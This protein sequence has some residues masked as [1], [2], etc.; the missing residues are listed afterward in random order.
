MLVVRRT[1]GRSLIIP[2][3]VNSTPVKAT[4]DTAA[5]ITLVSS[6]LIPVLPYDAESVILKGIG[7]QPITGKLVPNTAITI[8]TAMVR[9]D[10][11]VIDMTDSIILGL[12]FLNSCGAIVDLPNMSVTINGES[13]PATLIKASNQS[14]SDVLLSRTVKVPPNSN[15]LLTVE[16][17]SSPKDDYVIVPVRNKCP[18]LVSNVIG[19]GPHC[20]INILNDTGRHVKLKKGTC[21]GHAEPVDEILDSSST[22][23]TFDIRQVQLPTNNNRKDLNSTVLPNHLQELYERSSTN[24]TNKQQST[25]KSLLIEFED[26]FSKSDLDL[27]CLTAVK[28][29]ID[30]KDAPPVKHRMR[31]TP[32][33]FQD[34]E[35]EYL[36]K[37][38]SAGVIQPSTSEWSSAPVLVRKRDGSVRW[39]VDYRALNDRTVK[40]CFPL[41]IIEDC[42]DSLQGAT[43]FCTLDL[44]SGY[45]QIELEESDRKKTAFITR[46]GL[47]EHTRMGMGLCNAPAT[48][49]RAMQLVLRGLTWNQVLVYLD[50]VVILGKNFDHCIEGLRE[51]LLRFRAHSLKLKPKKCQLFRHEVEFLGKLVSADGIKIAPTKAE[52]VQKWPVPTNKKE[53]MA[54]LG[55]V[56]YHRDHVPDFAGVTACLYELAHQKDQPVWSDQHEM[57]FFSIKDL[58]SNPP[59]LSYPNPHDT[60]I[61]DTDASDIAVGAVLSQL[62]DN[63]EK[64][65][66]YASH[67]LM[68][69]QRKYCTTRKELLAVVKFCRHFRHYLLGRRF[70][71]R[72]DHNS[73][74][75]LM[76]FKHIEGQ[77]ARWL[78]ELAQFDMTIVHRS[79]KKHLN[80][81]GMSRIPDRL[82]GCDC[83]NAGA[84]VESLPCK[85][86]PYCQR[87]HT[88]WDRF[89]NDVDDV[90]PLAQRQVT[91]LEVRTASVDNDAKPDGSTSVSLQ[92]LTASSH[93]ETNSDQLYKTQP[94]IDGDDNQVNWMQSYSNQDLRFLQLQDPDISP[95]IAWIESKYKPED[96]E[97]RLQGPATRA[98][99][100]LESCLSISDGVLYYTWMDRSEQNHC[101]VV[102]NSLKTEVLQHCHDS[103]VA[104][105]LGQQKTVER[106]KQ[107][108]LWYRLHSDCIDYVKSCKVCNQNKKAHINP[109]ASLTKFHAGCPMERVHLDILGPFN[110][111]ESGNR[112][113]LM[114]IDQFSKW[115]EMAALPDQSALLI[116]QKF[117]VHFIVTF[118]CPLE[119][120]T[121]QGRNFDGN[122]FKALCDI[123]EIAKTRTTP[124]HPS[125]N[126]QVERY[127]T[128]VLQMIRCYI[129]KNNKRWDVDLPLLAM[130]LH[131]MVHRQTG[132]T[133]NR[134]MLGRE[135]I[136]PIHLLLGTVP[137]AVKKFDPES[138][139]AHLSRSLNEVH[140]LARE[141][142]RT[143]QH[144]Q[145]RDYDLRLSQHKYHAGDLVYKVDSSSK[146][147][148]SKKLK[149][150]WIGPYLVVSDNFPIY[151]IKDRK[152]ESV[153]HHDRLKRCDDREIPIW[154]RRMR[155]EICKEEGVENTTEN[156]DGFEETLHY[157]GGKPI[158]DLDLAA[159]ASLTDEF[160]Q[161]FHGP[162]DIN[163]YKQTSKKES[164]TNDLSISDS[165][166]PGTPIQ[167]TTS[168]IQSKSISGVS[169]KD[170]ANISPTN[171]EVPTYTRSGRTV[172]P[173]ARYDDQ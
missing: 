46:Y 24:L 99:W 51:A 163:V 126:G 66:C 93:D 61:L 164:S 140:Q 97:L 3:V 18:V 112:Y 2:A 108:F 142:L 8:G 69:P 80:A 56:N 148:H 13:I 123:L 83:Y 151:K 89:L 62:Q 7:P 52:A 131:S 155:H 5:M 95:L 105:H 117:V 124:Y 26:V 150:P 17:Q 85:G 100:L 60:F 137:N 106:V 91:P 147:G 6:S 153:V 27:G 132:Y 154:L 12:D 32:L 81:D 11:C 94:Y 54:F 141:N 152:G 102:P 161:L 145:K 169:P 144:R 42:L 159:N 53:L 78:E 133:P 77:L 65:I 172:R 86:C 55:F 72:T 35:Q 96:S 79:G 22:R 138:W 128:V 16:V 20:I 71:L 87:A 21:I 28:H 4:I 165:V 44:A 10:V 19:N 38:L 116:A 90:V 67:V 118:G 49:Q 110:E 98:L 43:T 139:I 15:M 75:W 63:K 41:P 120:H 166:G 40:D 74:V 158:Y 111:S 114:M 115:V 168:S 33:G 170:Q 48:F 39:C 113:I 125:S 109:R 73:L 31:R 68:K 171:E 92:G 76:R 101:L 88:Q 162:D 23:D 1:V 135:T 59:C 156:T 64:V 134:L 122:L 25:L 45:Y 167:G 9:W 119:V 34:V 70:I 57:A 84:N 160:K 121:D 104:G 50:D 143:T 107:S 103:R 58:L 29:K 146:I 136:Q 173:P 36:T 14:V 82:A 37:L 157:C 47:F 30:T 127:N 130:A 149:S 129:Q